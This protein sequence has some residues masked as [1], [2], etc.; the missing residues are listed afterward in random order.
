MASL[1][2]R[3]DELYQVPLP[4][5][6][7]AR[8]S[9]ADTLGGQDAKRV[10][11]LKKPKVVPWAVNQLFWLARAPYDRLMKRGAELRRAQ[12]SSLKGRSTDVR[13]AT[14]AHREAVA[15]AVKE[16]TRLAA[17]HGVQV[18]P[19]ALA[20]TVEA[21]SLA[22]HTP[23]PPGRLTSPLQAAG[24]EALAGVAIAASSSGRA[25]G[26]KSSSSQA[27]LRSA[28]AE[29]ERARQAARVE[30]ARASA[31]RKAER[32]VDSAREREEAA[33][34]AWNRAKAVLDKAEREL[35]AA[36]Q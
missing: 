14:E 16:A 19:D 18:D 12:L 29:E 11:A 10:K 24:F 30:R 22:E 23:E 9:L 33:R 20:R 31:V 32:A 35:T 1:E 7:S 28:K 17:V 6:V 4:A 27:E 25:Q 3:I 2:D 26:S 8:A 34:R 21:L 5:F 36:R 15:L 13:Q